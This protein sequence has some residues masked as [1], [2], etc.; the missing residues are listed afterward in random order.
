MS[1]SDGFVGWRQRRPL[2]ATL[3]DSRLFI[4][5]DFHQA[6]VRPVVVTV[7]G[8]QGVTRSGFRLV[9]ERSR[10]LTPRLPSIG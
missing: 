3:S 1:D 9:P 5:P 6:P 10:E 2:T 4:L 7:V 8:P